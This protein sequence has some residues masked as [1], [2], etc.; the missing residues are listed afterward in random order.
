[1]LLISTRCQRIRPPEQMILLDRYY[2]ISNDGKQHPGLNLSIFD[3]SGRKLVDEIVIA[4]P[5][6]DAK[7]FDQP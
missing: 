4:R 2:G 6:E 5:S 3:S 7:V 1:M